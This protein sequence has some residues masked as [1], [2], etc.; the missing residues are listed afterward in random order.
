[1]K[2][3]PFF[4]R[5]QQGVI[6]LLGAALLLLWAWRANF[7]IAPSPPLPGNLDL[8]FVEISG[9]GA[10]PGVYAF[11]HAPTLVEVVEKA[12]GP[13]LALPA[14]P[15]LASGTRIEVGEN[16]LPVLARMHGAE[17]LTLGLPIDLN[18]ATASDLDALPGIGPALAGRLVEYRQQHGPFKKIDELINV[19]GIGP[20]LLEKIKPFLI[21]SEDNKTAAER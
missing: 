17:L 15:A 11:D 4:N 7:F 2:T 6:L 19:S 14:N 12:G 9:P 10:H 13:R 18:A 20:K 16:G 3:L 8:I 1:M 21:I 5:A